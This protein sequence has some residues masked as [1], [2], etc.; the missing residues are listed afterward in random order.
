[1]GSLSSSAPLKAYDTP[2][3]G[4]QILGT[5]LVSRG[6][7]RRLA[8]V[9]LHSSNNGSRRVVVFLLVQLLLGHHA[10]GGAA[11]TQHGNI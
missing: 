1:M 2:R 5:G 11:N 4:V 9:I 7:G 3:L 8:V 10:I 6:K